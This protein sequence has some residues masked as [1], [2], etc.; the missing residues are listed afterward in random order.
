MHARGHGRLSTSSKGPRIV[1]R[2]P[3]RKHAPRLAIQ[4]PLKRFQMHALRPLPCP[5]ARRVHREKGGGHPA[6]SA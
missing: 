1:D 5:I 2:R 3:A 6:P 4:Q